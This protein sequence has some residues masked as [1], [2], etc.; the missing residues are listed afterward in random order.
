MAKIIAR[1]KGQSIFEFI[2]ALS[3]HT[4]D[5]G[6]KLRNAL[7]VESNAYKEYV[8]RIVSQRFQD[9][10]DILA[11]EQ[12]AEMER[13]T[14]KSDEWQLEIV[15]IRNRIQEIVPDFDFDLFDHDKDYLR[16][17]FMLVSLL[18]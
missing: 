1:S 2:A 14:S 8:N 11:K 6:V 4:S 5:R 15:H 18:G 7:K 17:F 16:K 10:T 9:L 12:K 13:I 3:P